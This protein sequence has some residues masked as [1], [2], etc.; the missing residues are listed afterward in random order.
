[1]VRLVLSLLV[2]LQGC[3][4]GGCK[5][6]LEAGRRIEI[7]T[8]IAPLVR[9]FGL[10]VPV[11]SARWYFWPRDFPGWLPGRGDGTLYGWVEIKPGTW[12]ALPESVWKEKST[13]HLPKELAHALVPA[14]VAE[15][16]K[17][18]DGSYGQADAVMVRG[19]AVKNELVMETIFGSR[20][21]RLKARAIRRGDFLMLS[22]CSF[23]SK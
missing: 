18:L 23:C 15:A 4:L 2:L 20:N 17:Y 11:M 13:L 7:R 8:D 19:D 12:D 14:G 1:M 5:S 6:N 9:A 10:R 21:P 3:L 16:A 22:Y